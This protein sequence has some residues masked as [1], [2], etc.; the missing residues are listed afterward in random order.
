MLP[1][2]QPQAKQSASIAAA[3]IDWVNIIEQWKSSG[4]S[5]SAYCKANNIN[6]N[7]FVYQ[8]AKLSGR[9]NV[10]STLLPIKIT[11]SDQATA[12]QANFTLHYPT[13]LKLTIPM[14]AHPDAIKMLL[15]C[16]EERSC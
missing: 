12:A 2:E 14:N 3:Q 5:Q 7:Q 10:K 13:G 1:V 15:N 9:A 6:Y 8:N 4:L 11:Q 16:L